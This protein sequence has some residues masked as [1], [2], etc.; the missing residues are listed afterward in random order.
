MHWRTVLS[1]DSTVVLSMTA[2]WVLVELLIHPSGE[3]PLNDDWS[4]TRSLQQWYE[5]HQYHLIGWTSMPLA[6]Q[7][8]WGML[9]CKI[10][11]FSF[12]VL[13]YSTLVLGWIGGIGTYF[14]SREFSDN[15]GA[16][17][18]TA[19]L[20]MLNPIYLNMSN[21]FMTD[22]PFTCFLI[23]SILFFVR[24]LRQDK[25]TY[26]IQGIFF[27]LIATMIRQLGLLV[28]GA[29]SL[30]LLMKGDFTKRSFFISALATGLPLGVYLLYNHWLATQHIYPV[31]YDEGFRR[32]KYN[33][34]GGDHSAVKYLLRQ[35]LNIFV[36][37][38]FFIF[39]LVFRAS[40]T[41]IWKS[42][43]SPAFLSCIIVMAGIGIY[44]LVHRN[45]IPLMG[46][47]MNPYGI[48]PVDLRDTT[49]LRL[50]HIRP[51]PAIVWQLLCLT[52][53]IGGG[54]LLWAMIHSIRNVQR[55]DRP[56][57][58]FL[59]LFTV[60]YCLVMLAGG[61]Y[62]RYLIPLIPALSVLLLT[63]L[64]EQDNKAPVVKRT[65]GR[66]AAIFFL[67]VGAW[68]SIAGTANY[69]SWNRARW[70]GLS[71]LTYE[72]GIPPS[73]ID[74]GFEFNG[75]YNYNDDDITA[76]KEKADPTQ[77]SWWWVRDDEYM[78]T[79]GPVKGYTVL[80]TF[81]C[82]HIFFPFSSKSIFVLKRTP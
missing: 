44:C 8:V 82:R 3:F 81:P 37:A 56:A 28:A 66:Y 78:I 60:V 80:K 72:A 67:L 31:K 25:L 18:F 75:Y 41:A 79:F 74:G 59:L 26:V 12:T 19:L 9:F 62:D 51:L 61:S 27:V 1:K 65:F 53:I 24:G 38:G 10:F 6:A 71:F 50:D 39:P 15:K 5:L 11:G 49:L 55:N 45:N 73:R 40:R 69:L 30:V 70:D 36:Y 21:T 34:F 47:I 42:R 43:R 57:L 2:V 52:G 58:W 29:F 16:C 7:L 23:L 46:N 48:G 20:L 13:R 64:A 35:A 17:F 14:L 68:F 4:Y 22:V 54:V 33:L 63:G 76:L 77:K 32:I